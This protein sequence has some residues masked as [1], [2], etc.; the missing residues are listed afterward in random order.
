MQSIKVEDIDMSNRSCK[1]I[2]MFDDDKYVAEIVDYENPYISLDKLS[3]FLNAG[4]GYSECYGFGC[5][6]KYAMADDCITVYLNLLD[7]SNVMI[8]NCIVLTGKK[9]DSNKIKKYYIQPILKVGR[10][11][12]NVRIIDEKLC[13][14]NC[15]FVRSI[16]INNENIFKFP[17]V[18]SPKSKKLLAIKTNPFRKMSDLERSDHYNFH[19]GFKHFIQG[20]KYDKLLSMFGSLPDINMFKKL[21][22][23]NRDHIHDFTEFVLQHIDY[24]FENFATELTN[25]MIDWLTSTYHIEY[26]HFTSKDNFTMFVIPNFYSNNRNI[27]MYEGRNALAKFLK[28]RRNNMNYKF[29]SEMMA[30]D[31]IVVEGFRGGEF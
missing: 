6:N 13:S 14:N 31:L 1:V 28:N 9:D 16:S 27:K 24:D 20:V 25:I 15:Y 3:D 7:S 4:L 23:T 8:K 30:N 12:M 10:I 11:L 29:L 21:D 18:M 19:I 22:A 17:F 26:I 2:M 5:M